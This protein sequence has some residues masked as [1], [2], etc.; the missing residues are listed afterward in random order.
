MNATG[1]RQLDRALADWCRACGGD[2]E[3]GSADAVLAERELEA[4]IKAHVAT[5]SRDIEKKYENL[6]M[7][8]GG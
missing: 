1:D 2:P 4:A 7:Q 3:G 6:M 5:G 8:I